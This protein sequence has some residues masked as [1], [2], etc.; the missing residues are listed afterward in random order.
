MLVSNETPRCLF[1]NWTGCTV[2]NHEETWRTDGKR[3]PRDNRE[4]GERSSGYIVKLVLSAHPL[5]KSRSL[6]VRHARRASLIRFMCLSSDVGQSIR[7]FQPANTFQH[8]AK[9]IAEYRV[10]F[11][12][13]FT[14]LFQKFHTTHNYKCTT[15]EKHWS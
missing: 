8:T 7:Y 5:F 15:K 13:Q 12:H 6:Q 14:T 9:D 10:T 11:R 2:E 3:K 1:R 4:N